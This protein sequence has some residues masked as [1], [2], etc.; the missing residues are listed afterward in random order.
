[1]LKAIAFMALV[2]LC[3]YACMASLL[4]G[5][6]RFLQYCDEMKRRD[7]RERVLR[8]TETGRLVQTERRVRT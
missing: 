7:R 4:Y 2:L 6:F 8:V 5:A 3:F 1:M